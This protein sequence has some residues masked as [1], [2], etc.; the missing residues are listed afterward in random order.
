MRQVAIVFLALL[1]TAFPANAQTWSRP[2]TITSIYAYANDDRVA[3]LTQGQANIVAGCNVNSF[4]LTTTD[5]ERL[6]RIISIFT[7]AQASMK[8]IDIRSPGQCVE[9]SNHGIDIVRI[10]TSP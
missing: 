5:H 10:Y 9:F 1:L 4:S 3:M 7:T 2:V 8:T 6:D